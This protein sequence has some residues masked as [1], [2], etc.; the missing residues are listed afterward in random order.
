MDRT[1]GG[2]AT[3]AAGSERLVRHVMTREV[4][5]VVE[6]ATLADV[7]DML[8][9]FDLSALPVIDLD[10]RLV[11]VISETDLVRLR[12]AGVP[13]GGWHRVPVGTVMTAPALIVDADASL[14]E[15]AR[16]MTDQAVHRLYVVDPEGMPLGVI[17]ESDLFAEIS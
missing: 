3:G 15:A 9:G 4:V 10:E 1:T 8:R 5:T 13:Q 16:R 14:A 12:A 2:R 11:G 7:A 17:T 6:D